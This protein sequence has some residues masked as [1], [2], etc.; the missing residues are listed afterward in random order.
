[1]TSTVRV[2]I[3]TRTPV[4]LIR[5]RTLPSIQSEATPGLFGKQQ[6]QQKDMCEGHARSCW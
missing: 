1:M 6:S 2:K 5:T 4:L 3:R